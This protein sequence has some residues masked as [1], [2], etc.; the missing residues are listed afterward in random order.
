MKKSTAIKLLIALAVIG[1]VITF[2]ASNLLL[3]DV[4]N[5]FYMSITRDV[6]STLPCFTIALDF[7]LAS[8]YVMR[9]FSKTTYCKSQTIVY[10]WILFAFSV[11]G[12][13][14]SV[15]TGL[16]IYGS[17]LAPYPFKFATNIFLIFHLL[18]LVHSFH[19]RKIGKKMAGEAVYRKLKFSYI[20]YTIML[21]AIVFFAYSC[22]GALLI[23]PLYIQWSTFYLTIP[24]YL[25]L[26]LPMAIVVQMMLYTFKTVD[27]HPN[28]G[29][30]LTIAVL[31]A[32][33][34]IGF[35]VFYIGYHYPQFIAAISPAVAIE[36]LLTKPIN[37]VFIHLFVAIFG[38]YE[39]IHAIKYKKN[40]SKN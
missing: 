16:V 1:S 13:F 14:S 10:S 5:M 24:F 29:L 17:M 2:Y 15:Y 21:S 36:R 6:V 31:I 26:L 11:I 19:T 20:L 32:N 8:I 9:F 18:M 30:A 27:K 23:S 39:L 7:I 12:I 3:S 37:T 28:A 34:V 4:S 25:S 35:A 38:I 33:L 40:H 22:F